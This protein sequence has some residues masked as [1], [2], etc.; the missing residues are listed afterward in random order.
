MSHREAKVIELDGDEE[1]GGPATEM[2][3]F[4]KSKKLGASVIPPKRKLVKKMMFEQIVGFSASLFRGGGGGAAVL[5]P[6]KTEII[7][8]GTIRNEAAEKMK[9][10]PFR[11]DPGATP[12]GL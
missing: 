10:H 9:I 1:N 7:P 4:P 3:H 8:F 12:S 6:P 5:P 2:K 11:D